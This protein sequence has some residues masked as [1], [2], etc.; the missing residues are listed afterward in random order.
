MFDD[1]PWAALGSP[2]ISDVSQ[3][4][5]DLGYMSMSLLHQRLQE[6]DRGEAN[7]PVKVVLKPELVLRE[8]CKSLSV[9]QPAILAGG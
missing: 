7:Q 4:T 6:E 9:P 2:A 8:S 3:P 1:V 5:H